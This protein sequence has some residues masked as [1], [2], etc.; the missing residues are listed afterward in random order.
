MRHRTGAQEG[1][2]KK[3]TKNRLWKGPSTVKNECVRTEVFISYDA[4][5]NHVAKRK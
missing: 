1:R 5:F 4:S 2:R 3:K